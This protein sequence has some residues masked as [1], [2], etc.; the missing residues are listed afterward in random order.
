[1]KLAYFLCF[2]HNFPPCPEKCIAIASGDFQYAVMHFFSSLCLSPCS[3]KKGR[4]PITR[5][6]PPGISAYS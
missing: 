5:A 3:Q 6:Q 1:L 2:G 4:A